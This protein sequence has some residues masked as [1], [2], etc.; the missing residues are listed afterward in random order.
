MAGFLFG[1]GD[2]HMFNILLDQN[3]AEVIH[4]DL[5]I[6]FNQG[7][8]YFTTVYRVNLHSVSQQEKTKAPHPLTLQLTNGT[9]QHAH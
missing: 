5:S 9:I 2:R 6:A 1:I 3:N 7:N 4:I 8:I